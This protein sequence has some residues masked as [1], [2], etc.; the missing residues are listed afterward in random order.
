MKISSVMIIAALVISIFAPFT[1]HI[2]ISR[3]DEAKFFVSLDVCNASGAFMSANADSP[4]LH[5]CSF[6]PA[7]FEF[8]EYIE[9]SNLSFTP[10]LYFVQLERPPRF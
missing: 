6:N 1:A 9:T 7:L 2:P 8:A 4:L 10:S 5:E 3:A